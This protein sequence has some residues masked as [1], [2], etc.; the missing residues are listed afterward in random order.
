MKKAFF[1][2]LSPRQVF[3]KNLRALRR[4]LKISQEELALRAGISRAYVSEVERAEHN[5]S[6]DHMGLLAEALGVPLGDMLN[7]NLFPVVSSRGLQALM[8]PS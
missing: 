6:I 3:A 7:P 5:V 4:A 8:T 1:K 2:V